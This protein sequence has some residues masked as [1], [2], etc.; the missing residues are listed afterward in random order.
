MG[1]KRPVRTYRTPFFAP[2]KRSSE[3]VYVSINPGN[4]SARGFHILPLASWSAN[5]G[6]QMTCTGREKA[7]YQIHQSGKTHTSFAAEPIFSCIKCAKHNNGIDPFIDG[8]RPY[9]FPFAASQYP[10]RKVSISRDCPL[11]SN[12]TKSHRIARTLRDHD[13]CVCRMARKS[14]NAAAIR[15]CAC[16][17]AFLGCARAVLRKCD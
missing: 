11:A 8:S 6:F 1:Q 14:I 3:G 13:I 7:S 12:L 16:D 17:G 2:S 15:R 4:P 10:L 9:G 5:L